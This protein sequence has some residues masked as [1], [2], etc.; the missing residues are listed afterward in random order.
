M[1]LVIGCK[2]RFLNDVGGGQ[3]V[4]IIDKHNALVLTNDGFEIPVL[5]SELVV[6]E[7]AAEQLLNNNANS[8]PVKQNLIGSRK[9]D[10]KSKK[11]DGI[12]LN[13][14]DFDVEGDEISLSLAFVSESNK[15]L[16]QSDFSLYLIN[17]SSYR[18]FYV[19]S[20]NDKGTHSPIS[21]G[22]LA[23][24]SKILI[25]QILASD[26]N[27]LISL[28]LQAIYFKNTDYKPYQPEFYDIEIDPIKLFK[29]G[30]FQPNEFFD[31]EA[32]LISI[33][34]TKREAMIRHLTEKVIIEAVRQK[35]AL[36]KPAKAALKS[37]LEVEEVDLHIHELVDNWKDLSAGEILKIQ[38]ARFETALE[39]AI[40]SGKVKRM[41]FIHGVGNGKL[42]YEITRL[43]N[44][45]YPKLKY[46]DA[47]FKEYG[48]GATMV[49]IK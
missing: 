7:P 37:L 40:K 49:F 38:L 46:Q 34:S 28:N 23:P 2:V 14:N 48:F 9:K 6:V 24:D 44:S 41:V 3:V 45:K 1:G 16:Q 11:D 36:A 18:I 17:D 12:E 13:S 25:K 5:I 4:R 27:K 29:R 32:Y 39:G 47:S 26:I 35:E 22:T 42:K 21:Y 43:L 33:A 19:L 20:N 15:P 30:N 8:A 31:Q 10:P